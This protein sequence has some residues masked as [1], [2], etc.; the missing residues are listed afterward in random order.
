MKN[1]NYIKECTPVSI[2][3]LYKLPVNKEEQRNVDYRYILDFLKPVPLRES[4]LYAKMY[5]HGKSQAAN[6]SNKLSPTMDHKQIQ[7]QLTF[8]TEEQAY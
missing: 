8:Y 1:I 6:I 5:I 4:K 3:V 7:A 2:G